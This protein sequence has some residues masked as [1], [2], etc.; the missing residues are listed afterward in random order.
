DNSLCRYRSD[1]QF[2]RARGGDRGFKSINLISPAAA[3]FQIFVRLLQLLGR[4]TLAGKFWS[5]LK[6]AM[7]SRIESQADFGRH[8][9]PH[10]AVF[11][12]DN[13]FRESKLTRDL[14][15]AALARARRAARSLRHIQDQLGRAQRIVS[16]A[17]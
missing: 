5:L 14:S 1:F 3:C 8:H 4:E 12:S 9:L 15:L 17:Y 6:P 7:R 10:I 11:F 13:Q 2:S 16:D